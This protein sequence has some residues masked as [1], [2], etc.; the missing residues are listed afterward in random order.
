MSAGE[1]KLGVLGTW[2]VV[3]DLGVIAPA[4]SQESDKDRF[5]KDPLVRALFRAEA[6]VA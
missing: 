1:M 4:E 2:L 6:T 5:L 3:N